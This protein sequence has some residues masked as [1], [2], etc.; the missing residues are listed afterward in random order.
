MLLSELY[1]DVIQN[2]KEK[3][4]LIHDEFFGDVVKEAS[5]RWLDY[6][7][8][9]KEVLSIGVDSSWNKRSYQGIDLFVTDCVAV[10]SFNK[11]LRSRWNYGINTIGGDSLSSEAMTMEI[12][13]ALSLLE[14]EKEKPR[15]ICIDGSIIS[16]LI[17]Y[18]SSEY[19]NKVKSL[20]EGAG[21]SII[22]FISKNSNT[23]NQFK[24]LGSKAADMYYFNRIGFNAG[25]SLPNR[26]SNF[27]NFLDVVEV[28]ARLSPFVPLIKIE[29]VGNSSLPENKIRDIV[30]MLFCN[31]IKGYPFCLRLAHMSCKITNDDVKRIA[32]IYGLKNEFG[33]RE[34]L[35][36]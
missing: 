24:K 10:T 3:I 9:K 8:T 31:S 6:A 2:K 15:L 28:Y 7:P 17:R 23:K 29:F 5:R 11:V 13:L 14:E 32:S 19:A 27:F 35:N 1:L 12:D 33:S 34:S 26:N 36:E 20:F 22:L 21:D 4:S 30:D 18:K 16:N 25:F